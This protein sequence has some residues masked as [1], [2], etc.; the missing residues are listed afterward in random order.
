MVD[1][2]SDKF[3]GFGI[4]KS[5][6]AT[7]KGPSVSI[8]GAICSPGVAN[9]GLKVIKAGT[10][11]KEFMSFLIHV[12]DVLDKHNLKGCNLVMDNTHIHKPEKIAEEVNKRGYRIIYLPSYSPFLNPKEEL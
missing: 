12:M 8:L 2:L 11:W 5:G 1:A 6:M 7:T 4:S 10:K 3:E 9:V